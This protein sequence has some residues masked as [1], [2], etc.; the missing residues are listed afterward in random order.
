LLT[1][2]CCM[3]L[4]AQDASSGEGGACWRHSM[5]RSVQLSSDGCWLK[6]HQTTRIAVPGQ[7]IL[8]TLRASWYR[9]AGLLNEVWW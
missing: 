3:L 8:Y 2:P 4:W 1:I 5:V 6:T 9:I 7:V